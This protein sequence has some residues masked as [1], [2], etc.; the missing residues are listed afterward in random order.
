MSFEVYRNLAYVAAAILFILGIKGLTH[1]RTA[2]RGNMLGG[3]GMLIAAVVTV[4]GQDFGVAGWVLIVIGVAQYQ[5]ILWPSGIGCCLE[6]K[7][8]RG[9]RA[10]DISL[11]HTVYYEITVA[12]GNTFRIEWCAGHRLGNVRPLLYLYKVRKDLFASRV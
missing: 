12:R 3:L 4:L 9:I 2:V 11:Q 7:T 10:Q 1:P 8:A 5:Q 6:S